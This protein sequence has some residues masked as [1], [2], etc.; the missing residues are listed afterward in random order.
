MSSLWGEDFE[1]KEVD[2]KSII[3]KVNNPKEVSVEKA[4]KSKKLTV[5]EKL[6]LIRDN[7][8]RIL[9]RYRDDTVVIKTKQELIDYVD[10]AISN[11]EIAIDTETN[12]SLDPLT[13]VLMGACIYTPTQK[14][15]YIPVNHVDRHTN[16]RLEWQ[17]T[18]QDIKEQFDRL[19]NTKIIMHNGKFD[20]QVIKCT[21]DCVLSVYWDTMLGARLI[22][23][24]ERAAVKT[25]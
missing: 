16:K 22:D 15:A 8:Y 17:L 25:A 19:N 6:S 12:K 11:G 5:D 3:K 13:C 24:N 2:S 10:V 7:V 23:E 18:E 20:Y 1:I 4:I 21:C 14:N 9:G